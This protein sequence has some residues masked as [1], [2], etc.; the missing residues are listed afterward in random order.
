MLVHT[1]IAFLIIFGALVGW[2]GVQH[3]ARGFAAR[4]PEFG[5]AREDGKGC[6]GL[7]CMC[8][9]SLTCPKR[10]LTGSGKGPDTTAA[11]ISPL[12]NEYTRNQE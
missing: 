6:G 3:L 2:V 11:L 5:P 1:L 9:D 7:F 12:E 8:Q 10:K 4:H